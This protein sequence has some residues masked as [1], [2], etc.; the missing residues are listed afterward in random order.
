M[1]MKALL[2]V[3][4]ILLAG[5]AL[6]HADEEDDIFTLKAKNVSKL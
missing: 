2:L 4:A 3:M 1:K 5:T 6:V